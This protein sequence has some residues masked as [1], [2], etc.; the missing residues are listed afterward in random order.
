MPHCSCTRVPAVIK[1][2]TGTS[3]RLAP[4][5]DD[6]IAPFGAKEVTQAI[7]G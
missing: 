4:T 1:F 5:R 3:V 6:V 7:L 2:C